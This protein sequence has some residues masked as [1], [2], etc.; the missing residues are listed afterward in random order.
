MT[1]TTHVF[2]A[3]EKL[4]GVGTIKGGEEKRVSGVSVEG[5]FSHPTWRRDKNEDNVHEGTARS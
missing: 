3:L 4:P 1:S 5:G 2:P